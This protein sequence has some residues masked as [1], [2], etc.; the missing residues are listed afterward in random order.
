[1]QPPPIYSHFFPCTQRATA[2]F[3]ASPHCTL[4]HVSTPQHCRARFSLGLLQRRHFFS[5]QRGVPHLLFPYSASKK[6]LQWFLCLFFLC[7]NISV[8]LHRT[9]PRGVPQFPS[10]LKRTNARKGSGQSA[11]QIVSTT[12]IYFAFCTACRHIP[13]TTAKPLAPKR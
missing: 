3:F 5:F 9:S 4:T 6:S 11:Y 1:M 7:F 8:P 10:S 12:S 2:Q 13:T